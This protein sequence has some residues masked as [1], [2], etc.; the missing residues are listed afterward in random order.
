M[1]VYVVIEQRLQGNAKGILVQL[2]II[3]LKK[4]ELM[5]M[6]MKTKLLIRISQ[7]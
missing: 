7:Q 5:Q 1:Q 6:Q 2:R 3:L 4:I